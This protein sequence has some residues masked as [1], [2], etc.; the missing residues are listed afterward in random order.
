VLARDL[1]ENILY[2]KRRYRFSA[3]DEAQ[4]KHNTSNVE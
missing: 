2:G 3:I 1:R 4:N